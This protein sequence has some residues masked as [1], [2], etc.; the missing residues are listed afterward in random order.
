MIN[1]LF[2]AISTG[3]SR[4]KGE[5]ST[6]AGLDN[7]HKNRIKNEIE[8]LKLNQCKLGGCREAGQ[9]CSSA[10]HCHFHVNNVTMYDKE[11]R[12]NYVLLDIS[13]V[14]GGADDSLLSSEIPVQI[15]LY[16]DF[17]FSPPDIT[18][19]STFCFPSLSDGRSFIGEVVHEWSPSITLLSV[20]ESVARFVKSYS[21]HIAVVGP[22]DILTGSYRTPI[23]FS[24]QCYNSLV[25]PILGAKIVFEDHVFEHIFE[26]SSLSKG[27]DAISQRG[28]SLVS[29]LIPI[30]L[31]TRGLRRETMSWRVEK[32]CIHIDFVFNNTNVMLFDSTLLVLEASQRIQQEGGVF[33]A[34]NPSKTSSSSDEVVS[35]STLQGNVA[36]WLFL[37]AISH[38]VDCSG[39]L[40]FGNQG[41]LPEYISDKL[42]RLE[43]SEC[44][45]LVLGYDPLF[46]KSPLSLYQGEELLQPPKNSTRPIIIELK[47]HTSKANHE[48]SCC[49]S[50]ATNLREK[51]ARLDSNFPQSCHNPRWSPRFELDCLHNL[52]MKY[53][54]AILANHE[55]LSSEILQRWVIVCSKLIELSSFL[56]ETD[57]S[58]T[59]KSSSL[60]KQMQDILISPA[61]K[62]ILNNARQ[63]PRSDPFYNHLEDYPPGNASS[64][65][66]E[67]PSPAR[68]PHSQVPQDPPSTQNASPQSPQGVHT[69]HPQLIP[70]H[71]NTLNPY[72]ESPEPRIQAPIECPPPTEDCNPN[73]N[74]ISLYDSSS[75]ELN[76]HHIL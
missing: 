54:A 44:L 9:S 18:F 74:R 14:V 70:H 55:Q 76:A 32:P 53:Q 8:Q 19:P 62:N 58:Y 63:H 59:Q 22:S 51:V 29:S 30:P 71:E 56:S 37:P 50:F 5:R 69:S 26:K 11:N 60:I 49:C 46:E 61:V 21:T 7:I 20:V 3:V 42:S 72:D 15:V 43:F 52:N 27:R 24:Y 23:S 33:Q 41:T 16:R 13:V 1:G 28:R 64:S 36:F 4:L 75:D 47:F 17:P 65:P 12:K 25:Y 68:N 73:Q 35:D 48:T 6:D 67:Q 31:N 45:A 57:E 10:E 39:K 2:G 66:G 38:I 40:I 34:K